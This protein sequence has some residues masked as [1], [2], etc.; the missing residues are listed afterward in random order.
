MLRSTG[1]R[2]A[3]AGGNVSITGLMTGTGIAFVDGGASDDSLTDTGNGFVTAGFKVGDAIRVLGST[4]NDGTYV[5][6]T[7]AAGAIGVATASLTAEIAGDQV[8]LAAGRGGSV[9]DIFDYGVM[10]IYDGV[11]PSSADVAETGNVLAILTNGGAAFTPGTKDASG[12]RFGEP[13]A[14]VINLLAGIT[15]QEGAC[16]LDGYAT[17]AVLY[18]NARVQGASTTSVRVFFSIGTS[19]SD[20]NLV[21]TRLYV[22][23]PF[24]L[25]SIAYTLN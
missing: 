16:L 5:A 17:Y 6:T 21:S 2:N 10:Y 13:V 8:V 18:D 9:Q 23:A 4:S 1:Y 24:T 12:L 25:N 11:M 3:R 14:G 20:M 19:G 22:G 15:A 7:V